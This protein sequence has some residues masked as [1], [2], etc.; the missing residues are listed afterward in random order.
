MH[1]TI[2]RRIRGP[3]CAAA[4][5]FALAGCRG[6]AGADDAMAGFTPLPDGAAASAS[7]DLADGDLEDAIEA[8]REVATRGGVPIPTRTILL[9]YAFDARRKATQMRLDSNEFAQMLLGLGFPFEDLRQGDPAGSRQSMVRTIEPDEREEAHEAEREIHARASAGAMAARDAARERHQAQK[10]SII[11]AARNR[12]DAAVE[13][14]YRLSKASREEHAAG[15]DAARLERDAAL[16]ALDD[17]KREAKALDAA[18]HRGLEAQSAAQRVESMAARQVGPN[19]EAGRQL[20]EL[21]AAWVRAAAAD[22]DHP[23]SFVPL[24]LAEIARRQSDPIDLAEA[25]AAHRHRWSLL[26]MALFAAAFQPRAASS[27]GTGPMATFLDALVP[28]AHAASPTPCEVAEEAWGSWKDVAAT[29]NGELANALLDL[30]IRKRFSEATAKELG[31]K[32]ATLSIIGKLTQLAAFYEHTQV[33]VERDIE[34]LHKPQA[35]H[36]KVTFT[37]RAGVSPEE[38]EAYEEAKKEGADDQAIRDCLGWAN[39]PSTDEIRDVAKDAENWYLDWRLFGTGKHATWSRYD[40]PDAKFFGGGR[41]G[42]P[43][44]RVSDSSTESRFVIRIQPEA[45]HTG[46]ENTAQVEI[47][48]EVDSA[49]LPSLS[50]LV[51]AG[52]GALGLTESLVDVGAGWIR[53]VFKPK[54]YAVVTVE[55][56]CP[57]PTYIMRY[58][59]DP[60]AWGGGDNS[61]GCTFTF[62]TQEEFREW[63]AGWE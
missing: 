54:A 23:D 33:T 7:D 28:P 59:E 22:P 52:K 8:T 32:I 31:K 39:L 35:G 53:E 45:G 9:G 15:W 10:A 37:A 6:D 2:L 3:A 46:P 36:R 34:F 49:G 5:L 60:V 18:Y 13:E 21:L 61:E 57:D 20:M 29:A 16:K 1:Q 26:E 4:L 17:A 12:Y 11:A 55:F 47:R 30:E 19:H 44:K 63:K 50:S 41:V 48:A 27:S 42:K 58:V 51:S 24:Y 40:N 43:M 62:D 38:L 14:V 25:P 56:H